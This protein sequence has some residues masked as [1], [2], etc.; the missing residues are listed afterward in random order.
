M[1]ANVPRGTVINLVWYLFPAFYLNFK[2]R[3]ILFSLQPPLA[4]KSSF[5]R[6]KFSVHLKRRNDALSRGKREVRCCALISAL[7]RADVAPA[8]KFNG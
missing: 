8:R 5:S 6:G 1:E 3:Y 7:E 4:S 2:V